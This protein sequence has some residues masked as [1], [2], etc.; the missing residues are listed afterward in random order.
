MKPRDREEIIKS[1]MLANLALLAI[2][3]ASAA[4]IFALLGH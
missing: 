3:V 4:A 1:Q 2:A